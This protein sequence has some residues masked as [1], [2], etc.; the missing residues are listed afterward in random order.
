MFATSLRKSRG[1]PRAEGAVQREQTLKLSQSRFPSQTHAE[2]GGGDKAA[3]QPF[4]QGQRPV[5]RGGVGEQTLRKFHGLRPLND[6]WRQQQGSGEW[7]PSREFRACHDHHEAGV[8]I[9]PYLL[10]RTAELAGIDDDE[11]A[12]GIAG[13]TPASTAASSLE[14]PE[15]IALQN[16][17]ILSLG[18]WR[19]AWRSQSSSHTPIRT[20]PVSLHRI[21]FCWSVA[22]TG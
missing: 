13:H 6:P 9:G 8:E 21:L 22:T 11:K 20:P 17:A 3:L 16:S 4:T 14:R 19:P 10:A 2:I 15:A 18:L 12:A 1:H 5:V 7:R